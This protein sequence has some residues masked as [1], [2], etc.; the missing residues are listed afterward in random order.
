MV[1]SGVP[2]GVVVGYAPVVEIPAVVA[3]DTKAP[4]RLTLTLPAEAKLTIDGHET[5]ATSATRV[6]ITPP[7]DN[8]KSYTYTLKATVPVGSKMEVITKDVTVVGGQD[9]IATLTLPPA[10]VAAAAGN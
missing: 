10:A 7:L 6:F 4:A 5:K 9:T 2:A 8:G 3:A 1:Y